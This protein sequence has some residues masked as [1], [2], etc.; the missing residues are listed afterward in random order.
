MYIFKITLDNP[1]E[2]PQ[3]Y[4]NIILTLFIHFFI[5]ITGAH[6]VYFESYFVEYFNLLMFNGLLCYCYC[7]ECLFYFYHSYTSSLI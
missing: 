6:I 1:I 3:E 4:N 2:D 7:S 5:I